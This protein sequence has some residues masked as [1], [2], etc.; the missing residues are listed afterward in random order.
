MPLDLRFATSFEDLEPAPG[1]YDPDDRMFELYALFRDRRS[2]F[3][4]QLREVVA[5]T[6]EVVGPVVRARVEVDRYQHPDPEMSQCDL[7]VSFGF[8]EDDEHSAYSRYDPESGR[9][10]PL[11]G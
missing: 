8:A 11:E 3:V 5:D 10:G 1:L 9:F 6:E 2:E 7:K 4:R